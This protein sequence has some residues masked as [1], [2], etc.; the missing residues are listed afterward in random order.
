MDDFEKELKI[1]FL[2]EASQLLSYRREKSCLGGA[3]SVGKS[4]N[5]NKPVRVKKGSQFSSHVFNFLGI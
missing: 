1:G 4:W 5:Q 3:G 2:E